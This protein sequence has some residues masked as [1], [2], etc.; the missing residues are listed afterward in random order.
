MRAGRDFETLQRQARTVDHKP[1][2]MLKVRYHEK[3]TDRDWVEQMVFV[4]G[5]DREIYS[6]AL[7]CSPEN[8]VRWEPLFAGVLESWV[9]PEPEPPVGAG[10]DDTPKRPTPPTKASPVSH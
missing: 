8:L 5:P 7:K 10:E 2:Q 4:E 6:V 9:L 3:A 1:A